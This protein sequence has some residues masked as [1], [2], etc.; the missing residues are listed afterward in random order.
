MRVRLI[1]VLFACLLLAGCSGFFGFG[2]E[3][4]PTP[5][6]ET[7]TPSSTPTPMSA[8]PLE[9]VGLAADGVSDPRVL[10]YAHARE[11]KNE[12]FTYRAELTVRDPDGNVLIE[13]ETDVWI[14]P[15]RN[16]IL[17]ERQAAVAEGAPDW[18][19]GLYPDSRSNRIF[20]NESVLVAHDERFEEPMVYR[21]T[22]FESV[23]FYDLDRQEDLYLTFSRTDTRV[24]D[25]AQEDGLLVFR[26]ADEGEP[27]EYLHS[28]LTDA[29]VSIVDLNATVEGTGFVRQFE[30]EQV[31]AS[32]EGTIHATERVTYANVGETTVDRPAWVDEML[33]DGGEDE[34][35]REEEDRDAASAGEPEV[36]AVGRQAFQA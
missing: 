17:I 36:G 12:S 21:E 10:S 7:P 6:P 11:L 20:Q 19:L 13:R 23:S 28:A 4:T 15:E 27:E 18:V 35:E 30:R 32:E 33:A 24:T 1:A 31:Y 3:P 9:D 34:G 14:N 29:N 22:D 8:G 16:R 26:L 5:D 2:S 25:T